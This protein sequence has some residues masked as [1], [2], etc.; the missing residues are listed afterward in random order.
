MKLEAVKKLKLYKFLDKNHILAYKAVRPD[1]HS[2]FNF[3]YQYESGKSY[4]TNCDCQLK[5]EN[6]FGLSAWTEEKAKEYGGGKQ[7]KIIK[8]KIA[9]QDIGAIVHDGGKLRCH[10]FEV[11]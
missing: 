2:L 9:V 6:S 7:H 8:V 1:G 3:Q 11:I 5:E 4:E 10:R